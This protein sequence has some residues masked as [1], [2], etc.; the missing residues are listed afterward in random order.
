M[1][2]WWD[3][4]CGNSTIPIKAFGKKRKEAKKL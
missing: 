3:T 2:E 1:S 4:D